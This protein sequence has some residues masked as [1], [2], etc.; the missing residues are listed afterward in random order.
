[1][2][3]R[4]SGRDRPSPVDVV[5]AGLG[6]LLAA[7]SFLPWQRGCCGSSSTAWTGNGE[8]AGGVMAG[9]ALALAA[10]VAMTLAGRTLP[11]PIPHDYVVLAVGTG[12]A[13]FG[14]VKFLLVVG[15]HPAVGAWTGIVLSVAVGVAMA[16]R[17]RGR[18]G[19]ASAVRP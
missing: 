15:R 16:W 1:L 10:L 11:S 2:T 5:L 18:R 7:A 17:V 19:E 14:L 9:L 8:L 3:I 13:L 12:A 4:P 6:V